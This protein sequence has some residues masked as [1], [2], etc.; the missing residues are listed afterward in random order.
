MQ[1]DLQTLAAV[2]VFV[3]AVLGALL[4]FAGVQNRD[5]R[6]LKLW[7]IAFGIGALGLGLV[8]VRGLVPDWLSI[9]I[10]NALVLFGFSLVWAG[11]RI[12]DQR[13]VRRVLLL[14]APALWLT[15]CAF[16]AFLADINLRIAWAS[17]LLGAV[18]VI[19]AR[20]V[21]RGRSEP[22]MSR[23]PTIITLLAYAASM[24]VRVVMTLWSPLVHKAPLIS[25]APFTLLSFG[26]LLFTVVLAFLLLNMTKERLELQYKTAS[27]VD[28]LCGVP[29]RRAFLEGIN[30]LLARQSADR[31]PIAVILFD[32]DRF[33]DINDRL[34]HAVGDT[35]LQVFATTATRALGAD[36]MF[37]RIGGEEFAAALAVRELGEAVVLAERVRRNFESDAVLHGAGDLTPTVSVGVTF[38]SNPQQLTVKGLLA[39]ADRALYGAKSNGRNRVESAAATADAST[40]PAQRA[41]YGE[42]RTWRK[43]AGVCRTAVASN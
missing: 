15:A 37:G 21:W 3:T 39:A 36:V 34:G 7:G 5:V 16:P 13:P 33:K 28:S 41:K 22:L 38:D 17:G 4:V 1:I 6:A 18:S 24:L 32:L 43:A 9:N 30:R 35:V 14:A 42:R 20:E 25:G 40:L 2:T 31:A 12:F 29:N 19:T 10:A 23:W 26:T 27:L 8:I 11:S